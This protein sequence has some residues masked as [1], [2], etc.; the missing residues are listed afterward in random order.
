MAKSRKSKGKAV[1]LAVTTTSLIDSSKG[2]GVGK[3]ES[4][5]ERPDLIPQKHGGALLSGGTPG[6]K[7]GGRTPDEIRGTLR[8]I[9]DEHGIPWARDVLSAPRTVTCECGASIEPPASDAVK[10]KLGD[11]FLRVAVPSQQ[12]VQHKGRVTLVADTGS[13]SD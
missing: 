9:L 6:Q 7:G 3:A 12:E 13:L 4:A 1:E 10:A 2:V 5:A 8:Q 11:T